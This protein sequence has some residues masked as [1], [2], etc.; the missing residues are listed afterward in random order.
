MKAT[1]RKE[2]ELYWLLAANFGRLAFGL[3]DAAM[4]ADCSYGYA[5]KL[6]GGLESKGW[7]RRA[8]KRTFT[9]RPIEKIGQEMLSAF[10]NPKFRPELA[11]NQSIHSLKEKRIKFVIGRPQARDYWGVML[12]EPRSTRTRIYLTPRERRKFPYEHSNVLEVKT[13][14]DRGIFERAVDYFD[15]HIL[16]LEDTVISYLSDPGTT[17]EMAGL[18]T[19]ICKNLEEFDFRYFIEKVRKGKL[20]QRAGYVL[21]LAAHLTADRRVRKATKQ[22]GKRFAERDSL[23]CKDLSFTEAIPVSRKTKALRKKWNIDAVV[24]LMDSRRMA[25]EYGAA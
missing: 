5:K 3:E 24:T 21:E 19:L 20:E 16:G 4:L 7:V 10:R 18:P 11:F 22:I 8:R 17:R 12:F 14:S 23:E 1:S 9:V 2:S 13:T 25:E 15:Y 6:V